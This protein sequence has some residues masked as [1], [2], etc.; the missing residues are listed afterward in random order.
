MR[1]QKY[2]CIIS[3]QFYRRLSIL[4]QQQQ[5]PL[6]PTTSLSSSWTNT[7][8]SK[9][10]STARYFT[11]NTTT[12]IKKSSSLPP[13][14]K[15][16]HRIVC[17][18]HG[19]SAFNNANIFT[20]WCDVSLTPRGV[21]EAIE[22]GE[23]FHSHHIIFR[24]CYTSLLTRSIITAH[25]TLEAAGISYIPIIYDWKLNERHY[26]ALQGLSKDRIAIQLGTKRVM[27]WRRSYD[28]K[29]PIMTNNHPHYNIIQNDIRYQHV[30]KQI[31]LT[32]SLYDCQIRVIDVWNNI[33]KDIQNSF[34]STTEV[35]KEKSSLSSK[36]Y[37]HEQQQYLDSMPYTLIVAHANS[38]RALVMY[39][40]NIPQDDIENLN[41]PTA[42]PFYYDI[43]IQTGKVIDNFSIK[44]KENIARKMK[45]IFR[46]IYI[47]DDRK[48]YNFL[49]RRRVAN[50]PWSWAL[51]DDH[52]SHSIL[53]T[54]E[55]TDN[56]DSDSNDNNHDDIVI[57][58]TTE[59]KV[60][61]YDH[62]ND[63]TLEE[64]DD[65]F[66]FNDPT[67]YDEAKKN[68]EMFSDT[69]SPATTGG[70]TTSK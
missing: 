48:K 35:E 2:H 8:T 5:L 16:C 34:N 43:D 21:V 29:P 55:T 63:T 57:H 58:T 26:G 42:I 19:E 61:K 40:D 44:R 32:E 53:T 9:Q 45:G 52:V 28:S 49:E 20:G 65:D 62:N 11:T 33:I 47:S 25:R 13:I 18:R 15:N 50:D 4:Q 23:V 30:K 51:H 36:N 12:Y 3:N 37:N 46:G 66:I 41:I 17:M 60:I 38:L 69:T 27:K 56:D 68:T 59:E 39:L 6:K 22:T 54:E 31:P 64:D 14:P 70:T 1:G 24:K 67:I 7:T 10:S